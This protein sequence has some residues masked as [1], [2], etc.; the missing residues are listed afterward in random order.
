MKDRSSWFFRWLLA[1]VYCMAGVSL[2]VGLA[3]CTTAY[4]N[5]SQAPQ[6]PPAP[7]APPPQ[8]TPQSDEVKRLLA[9]AA[10]QIQAK[11]LTTPAGD[12]ALES[13]QRALALEPAQPDTLEAVFR[14]RERIAEVYLDLADQALRRSDQQRARQLLDRATSV[15]PE[16]LG[17]AALK[18]RLRLM[19][20]A[21]THSVAL[22][23]REL[24]LRSS[25][26]AGTLLEAGA[27]AK[28]TTAFIQIRARTD[29]EGRWIYEQLNRA[30]GGRL[31][32]EILRASE[33]RI[34]T[35]INRT[36]KPC[37]TCTCSTC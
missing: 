31:R 3:G 19:A 22:D 27:A 37:E 25:T 33:P 5:T 35:T 15:D 6:P 34:S 20:A 16:H 9:K 14:G 18:E 30:P 2:M 24:D 36:S 4:T 32:A 12:N 13:L 8:P 21:Q 17:I 11:S 23:Q 29:A 7:V 1:P 10:A 26:L 28:R